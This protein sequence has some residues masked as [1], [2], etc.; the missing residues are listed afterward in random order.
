MGETDGICR[1]TKLF[2]VTECVSMSHTKKQM[3]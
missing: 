3:F 1:M 2:S